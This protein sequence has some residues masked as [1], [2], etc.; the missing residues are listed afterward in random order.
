MFGKLTPD[1]HNITAG[2]CTTTNRFVFLLSLPIDDHGLAVWMRTWSGQVPGIRESM[3]MVSFG[4]VLRRA[5]GR[6]NRTAQ[7][8]LPR[9]WPGQLV[10]NEFQLFLVVILSKPEADYRVPILS[11]EP[12][13]PLQI[14]ANK[15]VAIGRIVVSYSWDNLVKTH[16]E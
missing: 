13:E 7:Q 8:P 5:R 16:P 4:C 14:N 12:L 6:S 15:Y 9:E 1:M 3:R 11:I 2:D 10:R